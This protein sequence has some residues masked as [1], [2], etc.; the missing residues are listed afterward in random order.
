M[1]LG[2]KMISK[3]GNREQNKYKNLSPFPKLL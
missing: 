2:S 1:R 3:D